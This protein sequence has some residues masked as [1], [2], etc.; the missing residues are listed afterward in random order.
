MQNNFKIQ[1]ITVLYNSSH[2]YED[3]FKLLSK[4]GIDFD[5]YLVDNN[6][7]SE[8][9]TELLQYKDQ[10]FTLIQ[11]AE[12]KMFTRAVNQCI[13]QDYDYTLLLNPDTFLVRE[14][15]LK[16]WLMIHTL[17]KMGI[18]GVRLQDQKG[19][20]VHCGAFTTGDPMRLENNMHRGFG[21][22][23][24]F[25]KQEE[26]SWVTG[27]TMMISREVIKKCN[28]LPMGDKNQWQ[29]Y[30]SDREICWLAKKNKFSI[31]YIPVDVGHKQGKSSK[32]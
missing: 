2:C 17:Q 3:Y 8:H 9:I 25:D 5:L 30:H 26:V 28:G 24:G 19:M 6:S 21:L 29:H 18:S 1:I 13:F 15:W 23:T 31:W 22:Y 11:N 4:A 27:A 16:E 12:N 14:D 32:K 20:F 7:K 10:K